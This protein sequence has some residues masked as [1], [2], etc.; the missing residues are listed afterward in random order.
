MRHLSV[1]VMNAFVV[2]KLYADASAEKILDN[3]RRL[4]Q[5]Q[6]IFWTAFAL[7]EVAFLVSRSTAV[8]QFQRP[9]LLVL[10]IA[11]LADRFIE[12]RAR[13]V[14]V[15]E[16][17]AAGIDTNV[18]ERVVR[19]QTQESMLSEVNS[20]CED[21]RR[22]CGVGSNLMHHAN[23][24]VS[25]IFVSCAL[26]AFWSASTSMATVA[27]VSAGTY[28]FGRLIEILALRSRPSTVPKNAAFMRRQG[29][30]SKVSE[31]YWT[32]PL[33]SA[34]KM[35]EAARLV[36]EGLPG[37]TPPFL[38]L[39]RMVRKN[40][41]VTLAL[42]AQTVDAFGRRS[43]G[44]VGVV[45]CWPVSERVFAGLRDSTL[46]ESDITAADVLPRERNAEARYLYI[47]VMIVKSP[48]SVLGATRSAALTAAFLEHI[49]KTYFDD[50]DPKMLFA[51][52]ITP[53][54]KAW[55][56]EFELPRLG[57]VSQYDVDDGIIFGE[58]VATEQV[59]K[60]INRVRNVR[61]KF[62]TLN[63]TLAEAS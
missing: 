39:Y 46:P 62:I 17:A 14:P 31:L 51:I 41:A 59:K 16:L 9:F 15:P 33:T 56:S 44:V 50:P 4:T 42:N 22:N 3:A 40:P 1:A 11:F 21:C 55:C 19:L 27:G 23:C 57:V 35:I 49:L 54:G 34:A 18:P 8:P 24:S 29:P 30:M 63:W 7:A 20:W 60:R 47:P 26:T 12:A 45:S 6:K 43:E 38:E 37:Q 48:R 58:W 28:I 53:Q 10:S 13:S 2:A 25:F 36:D 5:F 52:G 61:S 32:E